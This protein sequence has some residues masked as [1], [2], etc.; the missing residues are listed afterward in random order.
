MKVFA[1]NQKYNFHPATRF[2]AVMLIGELNQDEIVPPNR[3]PNPL[4]AAW[5]FLV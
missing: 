4:P 1:T 3:F 2:N 5:T